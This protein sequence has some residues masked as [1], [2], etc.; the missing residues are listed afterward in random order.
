M[1]ENTTVTTVIRPAY[2]GRSDTQVG[3]GCRTRIKYN[4]ADLPQMTWDSLTVN[5][6]STQLYVINDLPVARGSLVR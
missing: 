4:Y 1:K 2:Y 3:K 6:Q 5:T